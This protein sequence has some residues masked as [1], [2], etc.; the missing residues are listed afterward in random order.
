MSG[1]HR[2][3]KI[4][5]ERTQRTV[6]YLELDHGLIAH[7]TK[8]TLAAVYTRTRILNLTQAEGQIHAFGFQSFCSSANLLTSVFLE[9]FRLRG[10]RQTVAPRDAWRHHLAAG[11][12][13]LGSVTGPTL[14]KKPP[15]VWHRWDAIE[16][17][18]SFSSLIHVD[19]IILFTIEEGWN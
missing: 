1:Y 15:A 6:C 18:R 17:A 14:R 10:K 4:S 9:K 11:T 7:G 5:G 12:A 3:D 19:L 2:K 8:A 13:N 16:L